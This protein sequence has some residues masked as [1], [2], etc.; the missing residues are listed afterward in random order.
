NDSHSNLIMAHRRLTTE[1]KG[2][3]VAQASDAP[4]DQQCERIGAPEF[5]TSALIMDNLLTL[6]G[7]GATRATRRQ[8][9]PAF[10]SRVDRH[11]KPFGE[12]LPLPPTRGR[13]IS[14]KIIPRLEG[15][16]PRDTEKRRHLTQEAAKSTHERVWREK[17]VPSSLAA[18][19]AHD[20]VRSPLTPAG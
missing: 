15:R 6:I 10:S 12:R 20:N 3:A 18:H 1:E 13:P 9:P 19:H 8:S 5:D 4:N 17:A 7:R 14:N 16:S 2:K 11:G